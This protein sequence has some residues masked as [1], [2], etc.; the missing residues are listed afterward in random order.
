MVTVPHSGPCAQAL[1][2]SLVTPRGRWTVT[3]TSPESISVSA[4]MNCQYSSAVSLQRF[5]AALATYSTV[6]EA[7]VSATSKFSCTV[8]T[9]LS[10]TEA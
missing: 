2:W 6:K 1:T 10:S 7:V 4:P 8:T 5:A 9:P 3:L